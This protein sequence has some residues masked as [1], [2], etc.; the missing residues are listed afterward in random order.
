MYTTF[1]FFFIRVG[2]LSGVTSFNK[3]NKCNKCGASYKLLAKCHA[4]KWAGIYVDLRIKIHSLLNSPIFLCLR[5]ITWTLSASS[6]LEMYSTTALATNSS[7]REVLETPL[8]TATGEGQNFKTCCIR[9]ILRL[10]TEASRIAWM[11]SKGSKLN[12][13]SANFG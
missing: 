6:L 13:F 7:S 11:T 4:V 1:N 5:S 12:P 2:D 3:T 10:W 9:P 8:K